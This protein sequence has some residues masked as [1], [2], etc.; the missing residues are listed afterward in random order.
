M[1]TKTTQINKPK[2]TRRNA[3]QVRDWETLFVTLVFLIALLATIWMI[4]ISVTDKEPEN[5]FRIVPAGSL[6]IIVELWVMLTLPFYSKLA[7]WGSIISLATYLFF[8][9]PFVFLGLLP[10]ELSI[11]AGIFI[12]ISLVCC[13]MLIRQRDRF[14]RNKS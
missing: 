10:T 8:A 3:W 5:R 7:F 2:S 9:V 11:G 4:F 12:I 1:A 14:L 13:I 6:M